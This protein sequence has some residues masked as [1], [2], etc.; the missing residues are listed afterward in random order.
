MRQVYYLFDR[1]PGRLGRQPGISLTDVIDH[2]NKMQRGRAEPLLLP[3][4]AR[5][6]H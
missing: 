4:G 6:S 2:L 3:V 5:C 1:H